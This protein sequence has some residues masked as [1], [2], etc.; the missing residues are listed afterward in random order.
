MGPVLWSSDLSVFA[1]QNPY[2]LGSHI[3]MLH[4]SPL[5]MGISH[6]EKN[7]YWAFGGLANALFWYD[8]GL[9]H[10][11]GQDDHSDGKVLEY[12]EGQVRYLP[13]V[14]SHLFYRSDNQMLYV[15]DSGNKRI[16]MLD[17]TTG[18]PGATIVTP[19]PIALAQKMDGAV[20]TTLISG[21]PLD[22]PSG[23]ELRDSIYVSDNK[24]SHILAYGF[25]G[26]LQNWLDTGLPT[27]SLSGMAFGPDGNL[28]FVDMLGDRVLRIDP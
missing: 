2:G 6:V 19:E 23:L 28:Y 13:G 26:S 14:P 9:D 11:I 10:G 27:G 3:D 24:T 18:T 16:A 25:D 21:A 1:E 4:E 15:A 20:I 5:C 12:A 22:T 7:I 8:F 17:T